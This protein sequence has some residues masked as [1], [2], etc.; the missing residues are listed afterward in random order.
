MVAHGN[1]EA[2]LLFVDESHMAVASAQKTFV[3]AGLK[4]SAIFRVGDC[5][6]DSADESAD[7]IL[8]NPPFHQ[9]Q[10]MGDAVAWR[11]FSQAQKA[12]RP[13]GELWVIGNR[14]LSYQEKLKHLFGNVE[15]MASNKKFV[16]L[17]SQVRQGHS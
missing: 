14:H 10:V 1:P 5:L 16:I 4:N 8:C 13:G 2:N 15:Q 6:S 9:Q 11:M 3:E 12:L 7:L 17:R